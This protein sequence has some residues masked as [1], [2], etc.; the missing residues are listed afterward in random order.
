M[1]RSFLLFLFLL[2]NFDLV[3]L[4]QLRFEFEHIAR[5]YELGWR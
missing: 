3:D 1:D 5:R 4:S 2:S